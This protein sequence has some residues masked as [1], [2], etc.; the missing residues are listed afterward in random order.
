MPPP[1][2]QFSFG[3]FGDIVTLIQIALY[4]KKLVT[5]HMS[6]QSELR[7]IAEFLTNYV[8]VLLAIQSVLES[9]QAQALPPEACNA[10]IFS[11]QASLKSL[12]DFQSRTENFVGEV[13]GFAQL[14]RMVW[15]TFNSQADFQDLQKRLLDHGNVI[16]Q[17]LSLCNL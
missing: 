16:T 6:F 14:V 13:S 12:T 8:T 15:R 10:I 2:V 4:V 3:S 17:V 1:V 5:G 7:D 11:L 9:P